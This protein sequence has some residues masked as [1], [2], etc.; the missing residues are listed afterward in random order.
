MAIPAILPPILKAV[1]LDVDGTLIDSN[2]AYALAY[3]EA[4]RSGAR[5]RSSTI[6]RIFC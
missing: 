1:L 4:R 5:L 6:Q 3:V 2:R